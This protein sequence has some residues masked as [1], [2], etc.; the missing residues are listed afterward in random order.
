MSRPLL[1]A[2]ILFSF[3]RP[4]SAQTTSPG[5]PTVGDSTARVDK[6]FEKWNRT[7]SPGVKSEQLTRLRCAGI[8][9]H[10]DKT[11]LGEHSPVECLTLRPITRAMAH[12]WKFRNYTMAHV[13]E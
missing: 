12:F 5:L 4:A 11:R 7:D 3:V 9:S 10:D 6:L 1:F 13:P 8:V 2:L